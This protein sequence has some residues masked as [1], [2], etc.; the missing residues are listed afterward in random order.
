MKKYIVKLLS[1]E[2]ENLLSLISKGKSSARKLTHGRIL[3][4]ADETIGVRKTDEEIAEAVHV[5]VKTVQRVRQ[6]CVEGGIES[7]LE[8]TPH[9]RYKP[10]KIQGKEEAQLIAVCCSKPPEGRSRWTLKLLSEKLVS[11]EVIDTVSSQ[12]IGRVLEKNELKPWRNKEWCIPEAN[13]DFVCHMRI[14][15]N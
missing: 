4:E 1:D 8:R 9:K 7:A 12:T 3:L 15:Q 6:A 10:H 2:R 5:N 11:L 13:A 14:L